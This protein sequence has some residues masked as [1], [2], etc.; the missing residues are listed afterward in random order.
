MIGTACAVSFAESLVEPGESLTWWDG[1]SLASLLSHD[2]R[3]LDDC[4]YFPS[5]LCV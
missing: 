2:P 5:I 1:P 3:F 4:F